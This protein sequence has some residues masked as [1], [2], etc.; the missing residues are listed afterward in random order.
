MRSAMTSLARP[1]SIS[2]CSFS[3][4]AAG[5]SRSTSTWRSTSEIAPLPALVRQL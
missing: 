3:S 4:S 1:F 2:S 5:F